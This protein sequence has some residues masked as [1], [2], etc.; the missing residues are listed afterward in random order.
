[1]FDIPHILLASRSPRRA[2]LLR[3][4]G[5]VFESVEVAVDETP[6]S[7]EAPTDYVRRLALAKARAGLLVPQRLVK[8][9]LGADTIVVC[10]GQLLGKPRDEADGV[11]MLQRLSANTH[12][13]YTA[14]AL[15]TSTSADV[16]M[17]VSHVTLRTIHTA[18]AAEYWASGE[19]HD[20]AGGYAIQG[21]GAVFITHLAGSYSGVMGL[22]L[23]E[24]AELLRNVKTT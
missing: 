23:F 1:M 20:K 16:R 4:I 12:Q 18:E 17:N 15:V 6:L 3:Q 8:P 11:A 24:T 13:V 10:D 22:P 14:V 19:P 9:V 5:V 21:Y 2:E 7:N